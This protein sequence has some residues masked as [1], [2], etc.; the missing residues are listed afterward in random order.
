MEHVALACAVAFPLARSRGT[1]GDRLTRCRV[2]GFTCTC[3]RRTVRDAMVVQIHARTRRV[4]PVAFARRIGATDAW[5]RQ[6][7]TQCI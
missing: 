3:P 1:F 2:G 7:G 5:G 4:E 6:G